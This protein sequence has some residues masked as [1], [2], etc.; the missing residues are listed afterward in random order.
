M[1][2]IDQQEQNANAQIGNQ[3][4]AQNARIAAQNS[5]MGFREQDYDART[6]AAKQNMIGTGIGQI[7]DVYQGN[8]QNKFLA[9][10]YFPLVA[11]NY[12]DYYKYETKAGAK[13]RA[14]KN[15]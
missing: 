8:R 13:R 12:S 6:K 7:A 3:T 9:E 2:G 1:S 4:A 10:N 15:N 14:K 11:P 5:Q